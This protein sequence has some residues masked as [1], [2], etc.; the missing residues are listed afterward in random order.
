MPRAISCPDPSVLERMAEGTLGTYSWETVENHLETCQG[1]QADFDALAGGEDD[2]PQR[3]KSLKRQRSPE[4][5]GLKR[6]IGALN[7]EGGLEAET[8]YRPAAVDQ[9]ELLGF[10]DPSDVQGDLGKLGPY[11]VLELLGSGGMGIVLKAFD[12]A[13]NRPVAIKVLAL[14]LATSG[15][16]RQR[17]ARE[18]RAAPRSATSTWWRFTRWT[19]G[20]GYLTWSWSSFRASRSRSGST[21]QRRST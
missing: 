6:V 7:E 21:V 4:S 18:A 1:C 10:L 16:A 20:R 14:Q 9:A 17:F 11:R 5:P 3:M 12:P 2:W 15:Q 8:G 13:L 19:S